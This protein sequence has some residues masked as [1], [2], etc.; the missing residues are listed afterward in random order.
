MVVLSLVTGCNNCTG[1]V[2]G[3]DNSGNAVR[4]RSD[5]P[6]GQVVTGPSATA[7]SSP[8]KTEYIAAADAICAQCTRDA[9]KLAG[10]DVTEEKFDA[11]IR[12]GAR[13]ADDWHA[14][15]PPA[16]DA[17]QVDTFI[18]KQYADVAVLR[19]IK[20]LWATGDAEAA[21][22]KLDAAYSE[23]VRAERRA[24]ARTYGSRVCY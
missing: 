12:M 15:T 19:K 23:D 3:N 20:D 4:V 2:C 8:T 21:Q 10:D 5:A 18:D 13:M 1:S 11:L 22:A 16:G 6:P 9:D 17:E 7:P 14:L 24:S